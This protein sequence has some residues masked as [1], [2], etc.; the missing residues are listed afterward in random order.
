M[1]LAIL[2]PRLKD[3]L[4]EVEKYLLN[5]SNEIADSHLSWANHLKNTLAVTPQ[6]VHEKVQQAVG[7]VFEQVLQDAG[8]FKDNHNGQIGFDRFIA[9]V[10]DR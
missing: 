7:A 1:G 2:P 9:A 6:D 5:Q 4:N 3:E 10:N 8:V